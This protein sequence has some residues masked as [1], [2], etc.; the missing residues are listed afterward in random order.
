MPLPPWAFPVA[1]VAMVVGLIGVFVPVVPGIGL[2]WLAALIYA[3]ADDFR[4]IDPATFA[5]LSA[6]GVVGVTTDL[7]TSQVGATVG[8]A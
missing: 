6:L 8:G 3:L 2:I 5:V 4:A 7:W 1:M